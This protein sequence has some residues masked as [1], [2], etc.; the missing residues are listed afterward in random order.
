MKY[1]FQPLKYKD[2]LIALLGE[3][4]NL[5]H[6]SHK[7][8][9]RVVRSYP[10][11][12]GGFFSRSEILKGYR[13]L[14]E[15]NYLSRSQK[16]ESLLVTKPVRS[17]SGVAVVTVLTKPFPCPG[18][19]IFC[20]SDTRMP[21]SY[22]TSEPGAQRAF[23]NKFDPFAQTANRLKALYNIGHPID[24]VEL[25]IIGGTWSFYPKDYKIWFVKN[26]FAA[27]NSFYKVQG[28]NIVPHG[29]SF[30]DIETAP[31][32]VRKNYNSVV[33]S[34]LRR[35]GDG[36]GEVATWEELY[37]E[38]RVNELA[39]CRCVGASI[40][41]RPDWI[42]EE[43]VVFI[44]KLGMTK[45]QLGIQSLDEQVL[46]LNKRG[47][48]I[49]EIK[50][51][52]YLL[53]LA[54]FKIQIHYMLNLLG[55]TPESDLRGF[56]EL[57]ESPD[58]RP[59][60]IKIY[61]CMLVPT[62]ELY[63][64]Y[65]RGEWKPYSSST[66]EKLVADLL[67]KVP[68]YCRVNRVIRD[69]PATEIVAGDKRSNLRQLVEDRYFSRNN[70]PVEIRYREV[71]LREGISNIDIN[72]FEYETSTGKEVFIEAISNTSLLGFL[73]LHLPS[74]TNYLKELKGSALIREVHVYG[75][76]KPLGEHHSVG[77]QHKGIGKKLIAVAS[78]I[79]RREGFKK[80]SVISAVG[81]REYYRK[82]GFW[83]EELYMHRYF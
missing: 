58:F 22:I 73:R 78:T 11:P 41:T 46:T 33:S 40:E 19:C 76:L 3:L 17:S 48:G 45:V 31:E 44:R 79:A 62:A 59:D 70:E 65:K 52:I 9:N 2:L 23:Q 15:E 67:L 43:E 5:D 29:S 77:V 32:K 69:I 21:K 61:P 81:T 34:Y 60:E 24:K 42:D 39:K 7:E 82:L 68:R 38:H 66:L 50:E 30:E 56:V 16:I 64:Y 53:R 75:K 8:L 49:R 26:C 14:V 36:N 6:V 71:K 47:H 55:A 37:N 25:I 13:F 80:I 20:P 51:A 83:P 12:E 35:T 10:K 57:F 72:R 63:E 54:G 74:C 4:K 1:N 28:V 18:K 27:L